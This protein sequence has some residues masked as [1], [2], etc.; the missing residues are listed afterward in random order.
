MNKTELVARVADL[1]GLARADVRSVIDQ[2]FDT[3]IE[4]L[5]SGDKAAIA[6]F[7]TFSVTEKMA[8]TGYNPHSGERIEIPGRKTVRF[9]G[10]SIIDSRIR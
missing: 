5:E 4:T 2:C 9:K 1:T 8:R 3:I 6:G 7:G 10:G